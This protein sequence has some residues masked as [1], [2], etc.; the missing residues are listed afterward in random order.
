MT[1]KINAMLLMTL[2]SVFIISCNKTKDEITIKDKDGNVYTSVTFG[3][4]EWMVQN[5]K[6]TKYNDGSEIPNMSDAANWNSTTSGAYTWYDNNPSANKDIYG[7]LYN[8][9]AMQTGKL[10][11]VGWHV[12]NMSEWDALTTFWGGEYVAGNALKESGLSHWSSQN[13]AATN[14]SG[15]TGLPG[16]YRYSDGSFIGKGL[17]GSWWMSNPNSQDVTSDYYL[18]NASGF[19]AKNVISRN[20]GISVRC[21]KN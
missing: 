17:S 7:A 2:L 6:V 8:M 13:E 19:V 11:P 20:Y 1:K 16:G 21:L 14:S 18:K 10:C 3:T 4:Q 15:F 9:K 12:P 5:L